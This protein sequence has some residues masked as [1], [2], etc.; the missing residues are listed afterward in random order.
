[1]KFGFTL[2]GSTTRLR[3]DKMLQKLTLLT[4]ELD[5]KIFMDPPTKIAS[6]DLNTKPRIYAFNP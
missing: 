6:E 2:Y 3:I 4:R 5:K 1:M